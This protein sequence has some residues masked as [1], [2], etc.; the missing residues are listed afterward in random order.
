MKSLLVLAALIFGFANLTVGVRAQVRTP[1]YLNQFP[2]VERVKSEIKGTDS[3]DTRARQ[4][5]AFELLIRMIQDLAGRRFDNDEM[6]K[7]E[8][9]LSWQYNKAYIA[10]TVDTPAPAPPDGTRLKKLL[11]F[12]EKDP[13][14]QDELLQRF[15]TPEFRAGYY[16]ATGK[17]APQLVASQLTTRP[18][19]RPSAPPSISGGGTAS[20][21]AEGDKYHEAKQFEKALAAYRQAVAA[22]PSVEG[23]NKLGQTLLDLK[24]FDNAIAAYQKALSL[25]PNSSV[26]HTN[27]G[28]VWFEKREYAKAVAEYRE[29]LRLNPNNQVAYFLLGKSLYELEQFSEAAAAFQQSYRLDPSSK[30][31]LYKL[32]EVY[33]EIGNKNEAT[34]VLRSLQQVKSLSAKE[35]ED[36]YTQLFSSDD[37]KDLLELGDGA[38]VAAVE[39]SDGSYPLRFFRRAIQLDKSAQTQARAYSRMG[40]TYSGIEKYEKAVGAFQEALKIIPNDPETNFDLGLTYLRAGMKAEAMQVYKLLQR[41]DRDKAQRLYTEMNKQQA[42]ATSRLTP[43][44][45]SSTAAGNPSRIPGSTSPTSRPGGAGGRLYNDAAGN[46]KYQDQWGG[47]YDKNGYTWADGSLTTNSGIKVKADHPTMVDRGDGQKTDLD[48]LVGH[49]VTLQDSKEYATAVEEMLQAMGRSQSTNAPNDEQ[50]QAVSKAPG[51]ALPRR[52]SDDA[53]KLIGPLLGLHKERMREAELANSSIDRAD[54]Y[55]EQKDY[56]RAIEAYKEAL[57][58]LK[59]NTDDTVYLKSMIGLCLIKLQ[60]HAEAVAYLLES[61]RLQPND[62]DIN[63]NLAEAY[64]GSR[65]LA[66]A[67]AGFKKAI[68]LKPEL[69]E[70]HYGLGGVYVVLG[71]KNEAL[72]VLKTLIKLDPQLGQVLRDQINKMK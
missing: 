52:L 21:L 49:P 40:V 57:I 71:M 56:E 31:S 1:P 34:Q 67:A 72:G 2:T 63:L 39:G 51:Y 5:E 68:N 3:I 69:A 66:A 38:V 29:A 59:P 14:F 43:P 19:A 60:R 65:K 36:E 50:R 7:A 42:P 15:F 37:S 70:A 17:Q 47:V 64:F 46:W 20:Y 41:L 8:E 22:E 45:G 26:L 16:Q 18:N 6:S 53:L 35:F 62:P 9:D 30:V 55:F 28:F 11:A 23:Y 48:Q 58:I 27:I 33:L 25:N 13:G 12:Y 4:T 54:K 44:A 24:Q 61:D 10:Y 32:G